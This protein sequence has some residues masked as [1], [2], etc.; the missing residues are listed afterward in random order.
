MGWRGRLRRGFR[1]CWSALWTPPSSHDLDPGVAVDGGNGFGGQKLLRSTQPAG[2]PMQRG[3]HL[4]PLADVQLITRFCRIEAPY[5]S[6]FLNHY[7]SF[8]VECIHVCVQSNADAK[9]V[10]AAALPDGFRCQLH[11]LP[12]ELPPDQALK[13][14]PLKALANGAAYTLPADGD[15]Y[16]TR[17]P[18]QQDHFHVETAFL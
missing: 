9:A 12:P 3:S 15:E 5:W 18:Q 11:R 4:L 14:L 7:S 17:I 8:G 6:S 2:H 1:R 16:L 13:Q 10:E